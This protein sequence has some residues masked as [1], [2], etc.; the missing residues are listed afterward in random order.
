M[1]I[2]NIITYRNRAVNAGIIILAIS[3]SYAMY[4][5]Q[6]GI[7]EGLKEAKDKEIKRTTTLGGIHE[8]EKRVKLYRDFVNKKEP[9]ALVNSFNNIARES[10]ITITSFKPGKPQDFPMYSKNSFS[11][12]VTLPAQRF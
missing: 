10:G 11:V 4:M 7:I 8:L 5:K 2:N 1:D 12:T 3:I 6:M 9:T